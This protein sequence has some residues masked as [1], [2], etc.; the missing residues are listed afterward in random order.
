MMIHADRLIVVNDIYLRWLKAY[1]K[2]IIKD[3]DDNQE[4]TIED[5][6]KIFLDV[7]IKL[8]NY[9]SIFPDFNEVIR[10]NKRL[11]HRRT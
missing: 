7:K 8:V 2:N 6:K 5:F 10:K 4:E 1:N 3:L 11:C 9:F